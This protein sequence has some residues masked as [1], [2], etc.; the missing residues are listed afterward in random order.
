MSWV[1]KMKEWG[2][3]NVSFLSVDGEAITFVVV[4][5]PFLIEGKF[6]G[7]DT[8]RI[9]APIWSIEGF[10][11]LVIGKRVARRL[12]KYEDRFNESAFDLVRHGESGD[13]NSRYDLTICDDQE[14]TAELLKNA[15]G[16]VDLNELEDAI[17]SA[18]QI[19]IG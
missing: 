18:R 4:G 5:E 2:G 10:S 11:I 7:Q 19:A 9:G 8:Q 13:T 3:G 6:K 12:S 15:A 17:E 16:G 14:L 1:E